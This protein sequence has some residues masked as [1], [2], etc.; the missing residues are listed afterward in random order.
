MNLPVCAVTAALI[1]SAVREPPHAA[2]GRTDVAGLVLGVLALAALSGGFI[3]AGQRG[4]S[5]PLVLGLLGGGTLTGVAF[6]HAERRHPSPM[7]PPGLFRSRAY[8][9]ATGVGFLFNLCLYGALIC[10]SLYLQRIRGET[11]F[12]AGMM[13]LPAMI[14]IG[15]GAVVSGRLTAR[16]GS[17]APMAAGLALAA[18]GSLLLSL[19]GPSSPLALVLAGS[20]VLGLCSLAMPAMTAVA[21]GAVGAERSGLAS[22]VL[23]AARQSGGALGVAVLGSLLTAGG[24]A[25]G[26]GGPGG[27]HGL[28]LHAPLLVAA[29]GYLVAVF[30][31]WLA[32]R[33]VPSRGARAQPPAAAPARFSVPAGVRA[34]DE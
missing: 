25:R 33:P 18:A 24:A 3:E 13:L 19:A 5:A 6:A 17:R 27:G 1:R 10:L 7:L 12:A 29:S 20:M 4:W 32:T 16:F 34:E 2:A 30:L 11:P 28:A 21:V 8:T 23:N 14:V 31:S 9:G 26:H 15:G 22:G